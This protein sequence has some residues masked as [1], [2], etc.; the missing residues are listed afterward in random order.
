MKFGLNRPC[1]PQRWSIQSLPGL[2]SM[3]DRSR[4]FRREQRDATCRDCRWRTGRSGLRRRAGAT[5]RGGHGFRVATQARRTCQFVSRPGDGDQDR[6]L[7]ARQSWLLHEFS[8]FLQDGGA[9]RSVSHRTRTL[10]HRLGQRREPTGER[11]AARSVS[12]RRI[13]RKDELPVGERS[14]LHR[15]WSASVGRWSRWRGAG[16]VRLVA[17]AAA[18]GNGDRPFLEPRAGERTE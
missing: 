16:P 1:L 5:G 13:L 12:L 15:T 10:F 4:S 9:G 18:I 7:P 6:Q 8:A 11:S 14:A 17:K 2:R 3:A